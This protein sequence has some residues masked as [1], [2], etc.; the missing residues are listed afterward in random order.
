MKEIIMKRIGIAIMVI[1]LFSACGGSTTNEQGS[2]EKDSQQD[3][4][5]VSSAESKIHRY[6][7]QSGII[8]Y[9]I[10]TKGKVM[11]FKI[12]GKGTKK[13]IFDDYGAVEV[14][15]ETKTEENMGQKTSTH[16]LTKFD[17]GMIYTV[18]FDSKT[19]SKG[20]Q[21]GIYKILGSGNKNM[22]ETGKKMME[23][24][25]GK[26]IGEEKI[27]SYNCEIWELMGQ[28][29][30]IYKGV[31][32]QTEGDIMGIRTL[33]KATKVELNTSISSSAFELPD[34]PVQEISG[35]QMPE[36]NEDE[37]AGIEEM[38]KM[39][40]DQFREMAKQDEEMKAMSEKELR[41]TYEMM[42]KMADVMPSN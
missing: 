5:E 13:L 35:M 37:K 10:A 24:M 34:F 1:I 26:K 30:W 38:K 16:S 21:K 4:S 20:D 36:M 29:V 31:T 33:E 9:E 23:S 7:V 12:E 2:K 8:E 18:D 39:T 11:G 6:E 41:Q 17:N 19:I 27:L 15:D 28:K 14:V 22:T 42:K 3:I 40:F 32:L 25:G